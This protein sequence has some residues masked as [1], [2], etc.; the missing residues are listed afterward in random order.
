MQQDDL[1]SNAKPTL[2]ELPEAKQLSRLTCNSCVNRQRWACNSKVFQYCSV[3]K[4]NR[5]A[6]GLLKIKCKDAACQVYKPYQ[7]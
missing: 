7:E 1:L 2:F 3:Q 5:T 4:S 6:N